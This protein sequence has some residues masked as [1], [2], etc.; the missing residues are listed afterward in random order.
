MANQSILIDLHLAASEL[1]A[2]SRQGFV[3]PE[4]RRSGAIVFK[5]RFRVAGRQMV[6]YVGTDPARAAAVRAALEVLQQRRRLMRRL[7][8][9]TA[10]LRALLRSIKSRLAGEL[11]ATGLQ[12][13]GRRL[14][15]RRRANQSHASPEA[16][17][18]ST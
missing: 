7:A 17:T 15:R 5:L 18:I 14:R 13:H 1:E 12:F 9:R 3:A 8:A 16:E 6:R 2:L 11:A 4:Q 10:A